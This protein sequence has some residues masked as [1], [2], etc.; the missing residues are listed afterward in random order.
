MGKVGL[1]CFLAVILSGCFVPTDTVVNVKGT[2]VD[3]EGVVYSSCGYELV[4]NGN[5]LLSFRSSGEFQ[6]SVVLGGFN[7]RR[8]LLAINCDGGK[9]KT[10]ELPKLP[11][12]ITEYI[13]FG[14]VVVDRDEE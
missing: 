11:Q 12:S 4:E 6:H 14:V 10:L 9:S 3:G 5:S 13:D 8:A 1:A 7:Y 2:V